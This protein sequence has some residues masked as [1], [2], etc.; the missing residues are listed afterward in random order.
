MGGKLALVDAS[1]GTEANGPSYEPSISGDGRFVAFT[2]TATNLVDGD[3]NA[4][5]DVFLHDRDLGTTIRVSVATDGTQADDAS[6]DASLDADGSSVAFT[7][8]ASNLVPGLGGV[9]HVY[10]H[11]IGT[12]T[13]RVSESVAGPADY[14]AKNPALSRNGRWVVFA[15]AATNL[16]P[17]DPSPG[18]EDIYLYDVLSGQVVLVPSTTASSVGGADGASV[19]ADGGQVS[20]F[21]DVALVPEDGNG[22]SD[23]Y[24]YDTA[25]ATL[26]L[27]S[28]TPDGAAGDGASAFPSLS[29]DGRYVGFGSDATDLVADDTNAAHD[30]FMRLW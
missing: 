13:I 3:T 11:H 21:S 4:V 7:S 30:V 20:F 6:W 15:S 9:R 23:V 16:D 22:V 14:H 10:L 2:S 1:D 17:A 18:V 27:V 19:S 29:P 5:P 26:T 24:V 8:W 25:T 28:V 12:S